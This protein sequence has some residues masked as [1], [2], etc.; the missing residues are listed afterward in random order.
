MRTRVKVCCISSVNEATMAV[1]AGA[2]AIGLVAKMPS[3]P[4]P[5]ADELISEIAVS[6]PPGVDSF[7]LTS[8]TEPDS[9]VDHVRRC[10]T[11]VVQLV[12]E[13]PHETYAALRKGCPGVRIVQVVHVEDERAVGQAK[14]ASSMVDAVLLD[15]GRPGARVPELGGTGRQHD[16]SVSASVVGDATVPVFLAG[17]LNAGSVGAAIRQVAPY[18]VDLCSGVRS[19]GALDEELLHAFMAKVHEADRARFAGAT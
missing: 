2:D 5:I 1:R 12:D 9:V 8:E 6:T 18:G 7:L 3:G 15:S 13:V 10:G 11:T 17:G 4:G 14:R 19:A 16:W